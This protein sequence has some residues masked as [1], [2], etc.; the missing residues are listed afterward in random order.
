M[1]AIGSAD[2]MPL[3]LYPRQGIT[4]TFLCELCLS[5]ANS[6]SERAIFHPF[7]FVTQNKDKN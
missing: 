6:F 1:C 4:P 5:D 3:I 2:H 7:I